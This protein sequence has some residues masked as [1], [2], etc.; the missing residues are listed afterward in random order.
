MNP[1]LILAVL[2]VV[3]MLA[4]AIVR[5]PENHRGAVERLG[6]YEKA[7][8]PGVHFI[9]PTFDVDK[10]IDLDAAIRGWQGM[11]EAQLA[12]AIKDLVTYGTMTPSKG[13]GNK[14]FFAVGSTFGP[15]EAQA[16]STWLVKTAG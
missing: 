10:M 7:L 11:S 12:Q 6:R 1:L 5:I 14:P 13:L 2:F 8:T 16:L 9:I 15:R 3:I 4:K